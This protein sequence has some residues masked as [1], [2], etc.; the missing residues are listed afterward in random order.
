MPL[1][2]KRLALDRIEVR[3]VGYKQTR[4]KIASEFALYECVGMDIVHLGVHL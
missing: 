2:C 1:K 3:N 4:E